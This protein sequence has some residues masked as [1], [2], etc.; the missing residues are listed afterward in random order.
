VNEEYFRPSPEKPSQQ[1][2]T[3]VEWFE[4]YLGVQRYVS[5]SLENSTTW[6][7]FAEYLRNKRPEKF[8]GALLIHY[9]HDPEP[10]SDFIKCV[11]NTEILCRGKQLVSMR[12]AYFPTQELKGLVE[13]YV[14]PGALFPWLWLDEEATYDAIPPEWKGM[15]TKYGI[16]FAED[17]EFALTMLQ[18]SMGALPADADIAPSSRDRLFRLYDHIQSQYRAAENKLAAR[19]K[20]R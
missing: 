20:I 5:F 2:L 19:D 4:K 10:D 11:Q 7:Q 12:E 17:V 18:C 14:E 3:W 6:N 16:G 13:Q 15:L 1:Q 8:L 9:Q